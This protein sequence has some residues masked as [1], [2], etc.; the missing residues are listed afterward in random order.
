[1]QA[2]LWLEDYLN[3]WKKTVIIVSHARDFL[4][5]VV[6]DIVH[7]Q[8]KTLTRYKGDYT[9]FEERRALEAEQREKAIENQEK[10][11]A[12][13]QS[14][15]DRFRASAARASMAQSR[16]KA[17][18][19]IERLAPSVVDPS[20]SFNFP[21]PEPIGTANLIQL[22]DVSFGY[23]PEGPPLFK[24]VDMTI[25]ANSR[26]CLVGPNGVGKST[27]LK[28]I[29]SELPP[30]RG[31]V[32]RHSAVRIERFTQHH[33]DQLNMKKSPLEMFRTEWPSD[34]PQKIRSHLGSM[35]I[36][37][38]LALQPIYTLSGGQKSRVALAKVTYTNPH[39]LLLDE[40][41]NHLD[42]DT[43]QALIRGL[44]NF[45]GAVFVISHD[46]HMITAVCD[47]LWVVEDSRVFSFNGDFEDYKKVVRKKLHS[48]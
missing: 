18:A 40:P 24:N 11:L 39:L 48:K 23:D 45:S 3:N 7:M 30:T 17:M 44:A 38:K 5:A 4:D 9:N 25:T 21:D 41:T 2:V 16:L 20:I 32:T 42:L 34:P 43:V 26:I 37:G 6:T 29:F 15:V 1:V 33:V 14:F 47:E 13:M 12:H 19:K 22:I 31:L 36:T 10:Q 8:N 46:E 35:G 28:V 27:L